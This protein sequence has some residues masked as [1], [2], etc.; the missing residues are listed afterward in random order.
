MSKSIH[1]HKYISEPMHIHRKIYLCTLNI[2]I[3]EYTC[4]TTCI[5]YAYTIPDICMH[6]DTYIIHLLPVSLHVYS[7]ICTPQ[8]CVCA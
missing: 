1:V 3:F 4:T 6:I 7:C 2:Y 8:I 5:L